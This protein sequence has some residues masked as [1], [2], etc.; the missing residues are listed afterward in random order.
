MCLGVPG[1][2]QR[3]T[4][5]DPIY[6]SGEVDF[7]GAVKEISLAYTPDADVGD[8]VIVHAGFALNVI[9]EDEA[10]QVMEDLRTLSELSEEARH[11]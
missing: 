7:N 2:I 11:S 5:D 9:D 6:R 1:K 3:I 4:Q 8:Y 10:R